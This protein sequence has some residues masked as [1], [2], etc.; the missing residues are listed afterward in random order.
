MAKQDKGEQV[1]QGEQLSDILLIVDRKER[2]VRAVS[3]IDGNGNAKTV[4]ADE[5]HQ[6]D[7]LKID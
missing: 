7:F 2:F 5:K 3:Q 6:N 4:P 1:P